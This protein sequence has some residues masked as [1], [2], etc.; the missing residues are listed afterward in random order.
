MTPKELGRIFKDARE[1]KAMTVE[2]AYLRSRIHPGVITDI[3]NGDFE[4]LARIYVKSFIR[5][6]ASFLGLNAEDI[7]KR[8]EALNIK[9][10]DDFVYQQLRQPEKEPPKKEIVK[11]GGLKVVPK[12]LANNRI[13]IGVIALLA[14]VMAVFILKKTF[15]RRAPQSPVVAAQR[16]VSTAD[17]IASV[18]P[19]R[20]ELRAKGEVWVEVYEGR[21][22]ISALL[23]KK[24]E[25]KFFAS[26]SALR[27]NTGKGENLL[28]TLNG[29]DI[30]TV[31]DG[32]VN[33]IE[34]SEDGVRIG[35]K[36]VFRAG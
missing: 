27:V 20:L 26:Q 22:R 31:A 21:K 14:L 35:K 7:M 2:K 3:E 30:G 32:V 13:V 33:G 34:V 23:M 29:H 11:S 6:Y 10:K 28:F 8:F 24:G 5:K 18:A 25:K 12:D 4:R 36:L 19:V 9:T 17:T 15:T 16:G 1:R